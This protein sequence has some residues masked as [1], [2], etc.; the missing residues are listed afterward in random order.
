MSVKKPDKNSLDRLAVSSPCSQDWNSMIGNDRVR[1][2]EHCSLHV[3]NISEMTRAE[4]ARLVAKSR[5]RLCVRYHSTSEDKIARRDVR[6]QRLYQMG[7]RVSRLAA[8]AFS[9]SL[10]LTTTLAEP[11]APQPANVVISAEIPRP[12][13]FEGGGIVIGIV[14]DPTGAVIPGAT[15]M[16]SN[17]E[18]GVSMQVETNDS[19]E[20]RF[21][22]L[23]AGTYMLRFH[24]PGFASKEMTSV[25]IEGTAETHLNVTMEVGTV[26]ETVGVV[27]MAGPTNPFVKAVNED[28]LQTVQALIADTDVN[29]RDNETDKTALD[30]AVENGN[31][32]MVQLLLAHGANVNGVDQYGRTPL[33]R[34]GEDSTSDLVW[35][36]ISAGAKV[37]HKDENGETA[38]MAAAYRNNSN[39]VKE[40]LEAGAEV[41]I[42][43]NDG[44]TAL[45]IAASSGRV[46]NVRTLILAGANIEARDS[47]GKNAL[48]HAIENDGRAVIRLLRSKGSLESPVPATMTSNH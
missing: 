29:V 43:N 47:E 25:Y 35:D 32:E 10:S 38:L 27:A 15:V 4:A 12:N 40:L 16:I 41:N 8:S 31:R 21:E 37:N 45:I 30:H 24:A 26:T 11:S 5:G 36:L 48:K 3:H 6:T 13:M 7:R 18:G 22:A 1:F 2:C 20:F 19:G 39:L 34:L 46:N 44:A 28:D 9:A 14:M 17:S 42:A 33:M 23:P